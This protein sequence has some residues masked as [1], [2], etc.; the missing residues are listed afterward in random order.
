MAIS[1]LFSSLRAVTSDDLGFTI[2]KSEGVAL[3]GVSALS[4][5]FWEGLF[6]ED[7]FCLEVGT[8]EKATHRPHAMT[9]VEDISRKATYCRR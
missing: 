3:R 5:Q 4:A 7:V 6:S 1:S 2:A 8:T 9:D